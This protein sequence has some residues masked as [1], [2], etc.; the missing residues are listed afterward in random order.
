MGVLGAVEFA[1]KIHAY[2]SAPVHRHADLCP[3]M[4]KREIPGAVRLFPCINLAI[5]D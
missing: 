4:A 1:A 3:D 5:I 2:A